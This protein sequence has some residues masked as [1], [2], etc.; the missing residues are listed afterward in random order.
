MNSIF[1]I[2]GPGA[3]CVNEFLKEDDRLKISGYS[4]VAL[5]IGRGDLSTVE[6]DYID[7]DFGFIKL[8]VNIDFS[9]KIEPL[10][11][12]IGDKVMAG[13][14]VAIIVEAMWNFTHKYVYYIV[15][16][17]ERI[18]GRWYKIGDLEPAP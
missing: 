16:K 10:P 6:S 7:V 13:N 17:G 8:K 5:R 1:G 9:R 15:R 3:P 11:Y 4:E 14:D 2:I 18:S 12:F